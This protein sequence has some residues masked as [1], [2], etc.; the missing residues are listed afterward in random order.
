MRKKSKLSI[1]LSAVENVNGCMGIRCLSQLLIT[2]SSKKK[3]KERNI[4]GIFVVN[5]ILSWI[6]TRKNLHF[7]YQLGPG[8]ESSSDSQCT[9]RCPFHRYC[10]NRR[11]FWATTAFGLVGKPYWL[12]LL[13][14]F[15]QG[16]REDVHT[17]AVKLGSLATT[18][19]TATKTSI[20]N[21]ILATSNF[22]ALIPSRLIR[23][24][25]ALYCFGVE[26]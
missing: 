12:W 24:M 4:V 14:L 11:R 19:A 22:I 6:T 2:C 17:S 25:F 1:N 21:W 18:T 5:F 23:Q 10:L 20:K 9:A 3:K 26:F 8:T 15:L 13:F 7:F 16:Q